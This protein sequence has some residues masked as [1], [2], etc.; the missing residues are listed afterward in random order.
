MNI[1]EV[2]LWLNSVGGS[3][4]V[5]A[6]TVTFIHVYRQIKSIWLLSMVSL[7]IVSNLGTILVG[8]T[9]YFVFSKEVDSVLSVWMLAL[10]W[11]I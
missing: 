6:F 1:W 7:L 10:A 8:V 4:L 2:I 5:I 3:L 9:G 11:F